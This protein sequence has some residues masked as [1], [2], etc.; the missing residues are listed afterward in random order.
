MS[1]TIMDSEIA[2]WIGTVL[3]ALGLG[4]GGKP[5]VAAV[6]R[7][8]AASREI[9][10]GGDAPATPQDLLPLRTALMD[11]ASQLLTVQQRQLE[12]TQAQVQATSSA[13][14]LQR[15][16]SQAL[17]RVLVET[18]D[19]LE[20]VASDIGSSANSVASVS[21]QIRTD[22]SHIRE[23]LHEMRNAAARESVPFELFLDSLK[24]IS[25]GQQ[26]IEAGIRQIEALL[27]AIML[28]ETP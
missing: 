17:S 24:T 11:V 23:H 20:H 26:R 18:A 27:N 16:S 14:Q 9:P 15:E 7:R 13:S 6:V 19:R 12:A 28:Q 21:V 8:L 22:L 1:E 10:A 2:A 4:A 5:A 25:E 3:A